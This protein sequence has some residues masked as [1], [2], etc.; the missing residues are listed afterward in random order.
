MATHTLKEVSVP[1]T[2]NAEDEAIGR[3]TIVIRRNDKPIAVV[4]PYAVYEELLLRP[5]IGSAGDNPLF[6][7]ER[8]A[9]Q[10]LLPELL[11]THRGEW[12]AVI[13]GQPVEFGQDFSSVIVP[14]RRRF[15]QRPVYVQEI[16]EEPRLYTISSPRISRR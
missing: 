5:A 15:G 1:Y 11:K 6:E 13:D 2:V 7:R 9:F 10:R 16:A 14:V 12:V 4:L 8:A 3:D